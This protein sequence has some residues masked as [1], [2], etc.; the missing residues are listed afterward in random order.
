MKCKAVQ[1]ITPF[2][3]PQLQNG[4]LYGLHPNPGKF[5]SFDNS[6][7]FSSARNQYKNLSEEP[8]KKKIFACKSSDSRLARLKSDSIGKNTITKDIGLTFKSV[9]TNLVKHK[10]RGVRNASCVVPPKSRYFF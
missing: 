6:S 9:D 3:F 2:A 8:L 10:L 7:S 1:H 4:V 5:D